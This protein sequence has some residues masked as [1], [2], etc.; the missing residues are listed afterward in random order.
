VGEPPLHE[1]VLAA[2]SGGDADFERR[3][4]ARFLA[5]T[6][7]DAAQLDTAM[8]QRARERV[9]AIAHLVQGRCKTLGAMTLAQAGER[10]ERAASGGEWRDIAEAHAHLH[11]ELATLRREIGRRL[12]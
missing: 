10:L 6:D 3:L 7:G 2:I 12:P 5:S 11:H 8:R 4:L 9:E 1:E